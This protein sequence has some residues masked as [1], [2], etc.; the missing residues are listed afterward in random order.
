M[1]FIGC[2]NTEICILL[3][4]EWSPVISQRHDCFTCLKE[5]WCIR[6]IKAQNKPRAVH[7]LHRY[8][9]GADESIILIEEVKF[10]TPSLKTWPRKHSLILLM[11]LRLDS[12]SPHSHLELPCSL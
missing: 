4:Y 11:V 6:P 7:Y 5:V 2:V 12:S 1:V 8:D 10:V 9:K 3:L